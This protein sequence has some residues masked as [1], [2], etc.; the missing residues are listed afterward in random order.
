ATR[1]ILQTAIQ[2]FC[3]ILL[4]DNPFPSA[5]Q[6][7]Q[8][9]ENAWQLACLHHKV[10]VE[11]DPTLIKLITARTSHIRGQF[12]TRARST[13]ISMYGFETG[14]VEAVQKKNR[15]LVAELKNDSAFIYRTRGASLDA[16]TGIYANPAIQQ[17]INE[18]L[19]KNAS[20]D[21]VRWAKYYSPFPCVGF[22]LA[23]TA[24]E[25]AI[26]KWATGVCQ[27]IW[28]TEDDYADVFVSHHNGLVSFNKATIKYKLLPTILQQVF[29]NGRA[30]AGV[31]TPVNMGDEKQAVPT[32]AFL[33]AMREF[34]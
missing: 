12:K 8:W 3:S 24:I 15:D 9:A 22:A 18:V 27:T 16:H 30:Y 23:L 2:L 32:C 10:Q 7:E 26:D 5:I 31:T 14:V 21:G 29:Q 19:F 25:C 6:E 20:D 13:V 11:H 4:S 33:N 1:S 34:E 28:F 17:V